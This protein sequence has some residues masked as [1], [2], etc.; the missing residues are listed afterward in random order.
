M[1]D[2]DNGEV[3]HTQDRYL[4]ETKAAV[5]MLDMNDQE[6]IQRMVDIAQSERTN[7]YVDGMDEMDQDDVKHWIEV[8]ES[9]AKHP[10]RRADNSEWQIVYAVSGSPDNVAA[11]EVGEVQGFINFYTDQE[12]RDRIHRVS[13]MIDK[14]MNRE[15]QIVEIGLAKWPDA[16]SRQMASGI[17]QAS[18]EINKLKGKGIDRETG[19]YSTYVAPEMVLTACIDPENTSSIEAF[20]DAC[21]VNRGLIYYDI[22]EEQGSLEEDG[23]FLFTLDWEKL[24]KKMH[25]ESDKLFSASFTKK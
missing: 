16:P 19:K 23:V 25:E 6:D 22:E 24:N 4:G 9:H 7:D 17:R 5:R 20:T 1:S 13:D 8:S 15:T 21:F 2:I 11:E 12:V 18:L 10:E 14:D 3:L